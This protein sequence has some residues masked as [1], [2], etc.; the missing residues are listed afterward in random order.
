MGAISLKGVFS[1]RKA[2]FYFPPFPFKA[3][4]AAD[5]C[6]FFVRAEPRVVIWL[7]VGLRRLG[8]RTDAEVNNEIL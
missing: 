4:K 6:D 7:R 2:P 1:S 5:H 3:G 8:G